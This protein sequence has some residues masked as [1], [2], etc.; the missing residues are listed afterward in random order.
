MTTVL[1][2]RLEDLESLLYEVKWVLKGAPLCGGESVGDRQT[3][4][5]KVTNTVKDVEN[6]W[7]ETLRGEYES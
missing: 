5:A 4:L 6:N 3:L 1:D 7:R 2:T